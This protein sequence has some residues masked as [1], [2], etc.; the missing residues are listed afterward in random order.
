F[1]AARAEFDAFLKANPNHPL[2]PQASFEIARLIA[3]QG[4]EQLNRARRLEGDKAAQKKAFDVS[5][6]QFTDAVQKLAE[7]AKLIKGQLDRS[8][9]PT[10]PDE[11]ATVRDLQNAYLQ[12]H[13]EQGINLFKESQTFTDAEQ[14]QRGDALFKA[15]QVLEKL[16]TEDP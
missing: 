12:A 3:S 11:R 4:Q 13:L 15:M 16:G 8:A 6:A 1:A 7:A 2:A 9:N 14:K 10:T 5:R